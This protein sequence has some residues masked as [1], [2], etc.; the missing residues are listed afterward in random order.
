[1][2]DFLYI[3]YKPN[4]LGKNRFRIIVSLKVSK[5]AVIRNKIKRRIREI[6]RQFDVKQGYDIVVITNKEIIGKSF[7]EIKK[8]ISQIIRAA[9]PAIFK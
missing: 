1:M 5:K 4:S 9:N 7:Q 3:K 6:L 2:P 8:R